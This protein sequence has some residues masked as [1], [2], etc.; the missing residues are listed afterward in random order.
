MA[1]MAR[2]YVPGCSH[3]VIQR[4]NNRAPCFREETDYLCYLEYLADAATSAGIDIHS[5]A[6]KGADSMKNAHI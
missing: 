1:R 3:H 5:F 6:I 2:L 4:G